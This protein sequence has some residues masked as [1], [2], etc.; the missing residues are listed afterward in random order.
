[1]FQI[2]L[3][4][5]AL[6]EIPASVLPIPFLSRWGRRPTTVACYLFTGLS[7]LL[8]AITPMHSEGSRMVLSLIG[9]LFVASAFTVLYLVASEVYPTVVR[10][11]G[12]GAGTLM[13]RFGSIVAPFVADLLVS[14]NFI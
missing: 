10:T 11:T 4:S 7:S 2:I 13:G 1:M 3:L 6:M 12:Q 5:R 9:K 14:K 8:I